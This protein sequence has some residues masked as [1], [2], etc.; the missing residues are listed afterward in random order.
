MSA[1]ITR[2]YIDVEKRRRRTI[3]NACYR[4]SG[5]SPFADKKSDQKRL[6]ALKMLLSDRNLAYSRFLDKNLK[7]S[8]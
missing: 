3:P 5:G 7:A 1:A 6:L 4:L 2:R 8:S